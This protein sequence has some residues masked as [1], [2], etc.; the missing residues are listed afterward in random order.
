MIAYVFPGQGSQ[1]KGMGQGLFD[2]FGELTAQADKILGYSI[3]RLCIED[4][5]DQ[6][7]QTEFTQPALYVVNALSYLKKKKELGI[8]PDYVAGHSLG[9]YNALFASGVFDFETGL[10]LVKKRGELMSLA[11]EGGMAAVLGLEEEMVHEIIEYNNLHGLDVANI[12]TP[13]QIVISGTKDLIQRAKPVFE[14]A[15]ARS[16]V[17]LKVSGAFHSRYMQHAKESFEEYIAQYE[18]S[19]IQIPIIS[20]VKAR[21]YSQKEIKKILSEQITSSV[22][23]TESIRYLMGK[24]VEEIIQVGPGNVLTGLVRTIQREAVPLTVADN[25]M[26]EDEPERQMAPDILIKETHEALDKTSNLTS[27]TEAGEMHTITR[28]TAHS[29]GS[30]EFKKDYNIKYAYITGSMYRGIASKELVVK[31]GKAGLMGFY[32]SGGVE[33]DVLEENIQYIQRELSEGEAYG[34]NL[35]HNPNKPELEEKI[36][37]LFIKYNIRNVEASAFMSMTPALVR[38]R[39][40]GL[41][42]DGE[43]RVVAKNRVIAKVSR[44]EVAEAFLSPAPEFI[45]N[46]LLAENKITSDEIQMAMKIP[47]ADDLCVEA[48]S[49]GHTDHGV[50]YALMPAM[51][52]LRDEMMCKYQYD[53]QIRVGAAGGI[54]T[55]AAAAAAF[56]LGADFIVT[57]SINQSTIEA[58]TSGVP[59]T[60]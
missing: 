47:M 21:P 48:D 18:F 59:L 6:L 19:K 17:I 12:N 22:K 23:W 54:G 45:M 41:S 46:K 52:K 4:P 33:M 56:M 42:R 53:K 34:I 13:T 58:G 3:K 15:G 10:K 49:G 30:S 51:F 36:V 24:G 27:R 20:N 43:G 60:H 50:A 7:G 1:T 37:D 40:K 16:Y 55:P 35:I 38:Y 2:E 29:L 57:G 11:T 14:A 5:G 9:E 32:G 28:I 26:E 25:E 44:P 8:K 39:L 31:V